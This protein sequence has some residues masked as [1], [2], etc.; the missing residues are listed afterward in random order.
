MRVD[1]K[2]LIAV[3]VVPGIAWFLLTTPGRS[4][5]GVAPKV[6][7]EYRV[8]SE[9]DLSKAGAL[10]GMGADGWELVAVEPKI[11]KL[12]MLNVNISSLRVDKNSG[13]GGGNGTARPTSFTYEPAEKQYYFKRA[14]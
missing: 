7:W 12:G 9:T 13:M 2:F 11:P 5:S 14:R 4:Q 1:R 3:L 8:L 6:T 10:Q